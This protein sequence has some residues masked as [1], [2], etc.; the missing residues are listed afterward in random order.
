MHRFAFVMDQQVGLRTQALN[1]EEALVERRGDVEAH[2]VPVRYEG[3]GG[4]LARLPGVPG[5]VKGTLRGVREIREGLGDPHRFGAVLWATWAAKSVVDLVEQAPAFLVMDMTPIQM[6][7]MGEHYGYT[8]R[9]A[10]FLGG[11]KRRATERL[12][13]AASHFFPWNDW[14][15]QSLIRDYGVPAEKVTPVSPGVD[16]RLFRP[17]PEEK[18]GDGV[19]RILFIGGDFLRKGGDLL[20]RWARET[21][22]AEPWELHVGT[23][24]GD[25]VR[26]LLADLPADRRA[27]VVIHEGLKNKSPELLRLYQQS[28]VFVLPTRADCYSLVSLEAMAVGLPVIVS[29]LGGI[30]GIVEEEATGFLVPPDDYDTFAA[31]LDRLAASADLRTGMGQAGLARVQTLFDSR[32]GIS[33]I[34]G[35]MEAAGQPSRA[36]AR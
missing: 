5:G 30:P 23:R 16:T 21:Q 10:R 13:A 28:D 34:L 18:P 15:A 33:R 1:F 24:D 2:W 27:R 3:D 35:A 22:V 12:Y 8:S 19:V 6:E 11:L 25:T 31:R 9:R 17:A 14:V 32:A 7:A 26:G 29:N 4:L 36:V 20:L